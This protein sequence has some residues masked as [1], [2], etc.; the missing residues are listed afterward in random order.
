MSLFGTRMYGRW[1]SRDAT[2]SVLPQPC[3]VEVVV[4]G[5]PSARG[6]NDVR[7]VEIQLGQ[8]VVISVNGGD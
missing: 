3:I 5:H 6:F 8:E 2:S 1:W 7:L 4:S